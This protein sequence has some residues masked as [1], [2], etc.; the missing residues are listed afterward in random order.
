MQVCMSGPS[1]SVLIVA[2]RSGPTLARCLVALKA[3]TFTDYE[4]V[5]VDNDEPGQGDG[6]ASNAAKSDPAIRLISPGANLGFAAGNN[7]AARSATAPRLVLLNPDA[8]PEP[9]WLQRLVEAAARRPDYRVFTSRQLAYEDPSLLDGLGDVMFA[10]G[11]PYRG[12]YHRPDPPQVAP[13]EVFSPCGAAMMLDRAL[14]LRLGGFDETFFCYC[15]DV[16]LGYR[17]RLAGEPTLLVPDAVVHHEGS[18]SSGG[19]ASAFAVRHGTRNRM[20]LLIKNTPAPLVPVIL[21]LHLAL[22]AVVLFTGRRDPPYNALVWAALKEGWR[23][24]RIPLGL[25]RE[26][27]ALR[28]VPWW[29]I[30]AAMSWNPADLLGRRSVI[31]PLKGRRSDEA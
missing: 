19:P 24:R 22:L 21:P 26:T 16:D 14:F 18:V 27:Q 15:E 7:L 9:D 12:G 28:T 6:A 30:A 8:Y 20:W 4:V 10:A 11:A 31:R 13:G 2:Y 5:L 25:R 1:I 17:L 3:Q 29:E 23:D